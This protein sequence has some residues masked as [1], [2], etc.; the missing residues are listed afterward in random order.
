MPLR[1]VV[2]AF[3][4]H[5]TAYVWR[6]FVLYLFLKEQNL[7]FFYI[8]NIHFIQNFYVHVVPAGLGELSFP[9]LLRKKIKV[10]QSLSAL[11][12]TKLTIMVLL[13]LLF[14]VSFFVL[15]GFAAVAKFKLKFMHAG[16]PAL[17]ILLSVFLLK[18]FKRTKWNENRFLKK[19]IDKVIFFRETI[20]QQIVRLKDFRFCCTVVGLSILSI[21]GLMLFYYTILKGLAVEFGIFE[22]IFVSSIG[23]VFLILPVK[24]IGGFGTSEGAWAIGMMLLGYPQEFSIKAGF[25]VHIYALLNVCLLL[26]LGLIFKFI[27]E[28][29]R[30]GSEVNCR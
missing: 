3:L 13:I 25:V 22:I 2:F 10:E 29:K 16:V 5:L 12:I 15:F 28:K 23:M 7:S 9:I 19:L 4:F 24:S 21:A 1:F 26:V 18:C 8:L 14:V 6:A 11:L 17:F 27:V 30:S 20:K